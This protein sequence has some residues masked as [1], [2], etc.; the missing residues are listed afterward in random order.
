MRSAASGEVTASRVRDAPREALRVARAVGQISEGL[1]ILDIEGHVLFANPAF[2]AHHG[3]RREDIAVRPIVDILRIE[4]K[5]QRG[6]LREAL[7]SGQTWSWN[8]TTAASG[9]PVRELT[10]TISPIRDAG[11]RIVAQGPP[12]EV[13][14][15]GTPTAPVIAGILGDEPRQRAG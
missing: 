12:A 5:E 10:L 11:G 3:L 8:M 14:R 6:R 15:A 1:A 13:A 4:D 7:A 9:A 2:A